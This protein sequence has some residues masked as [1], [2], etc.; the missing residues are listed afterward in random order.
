M[1]LPV[2]TPEQG[3]V[4]SELRRAVKHQTLGLLKVME[5]SEGF[6]VLVQ[7]NWAKETDWLLTTRREPCSPHVFKRV[8]RL[9]AHVR[10]M[11]PTVTV[12]LL[13]ISR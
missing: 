4:K 9:N 1:K 13:R 12:D 3:M 7:L 8:N 5:T 2:C 11:S 10:N 6:Y